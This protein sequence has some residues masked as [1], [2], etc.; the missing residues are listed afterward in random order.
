MLEA[1]KKQVLLKSYSLKIRTDFVNQMLKNKV[2]IVY[3]I[4]KNIL[5][6]IRGRK[7]PCVYIH[8]Y[9]IIKKRGPGSYNSLRHTDNRKFFAGLSLTW[10]RGEA[11]M[12]YLA[13]EAGKIW[14]CSCWEKGNFIMI[15]EFKYD[16]T[17]T[18]WPFPLSLSLYSTFK[19][20]EN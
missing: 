2:K 17:W 12:F 20:R 19:Y 3:R 4:R 14:R 15:N 13:R 8:D 10:S 18:I 6:R 1:N 7:I 9:Q 11:H 5:T 16:Q